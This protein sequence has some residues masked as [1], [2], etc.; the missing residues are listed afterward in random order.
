MIA[1]VV[2]RLDLALAVNGA[3]ELT[4]PDD[5]G[6]F[7]Q[8]PRLEILN[9]RRARLVGILALFAKALGQIAVLIPAAM[10]KLDETRPALGHAAR[11]QTVVGEA[12]GL[13]HVRPVEVERRLGF[14]RD[15]HQLRHRGL[16]PKR[17]LI[18]LDPRRGLRI[19]IRF[20]LLRVQLC[21]AIEHS[22]AFRGIDAGWVRQE[23]HR[24]AAAAK[25][26]A[27]IFAGQEA[28]TPKPGVERLI[29]FLAVGNHDDERG[30]I[31]VLRAE[32]VAQPR[33]HARTARL[34]ESCL[35]EGDRRVMIDRL[36]VDRLDD[37][38][39]VR[40]AR[41]VRQQFTDPRA[42][43]AVLRELE[44]RLH[45]RERALPRGHARDALAVSHGCGQLRLV[46]LLQRRLVVEQV[47]LRRSARHEEVDDALG[48]WREMRITKDGLPRVRLRSERGKQVRIQQRTQR[49][50][51]D[52]SGAAPK[53]V[54]AVD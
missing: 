16:H 26:H 36:G 1:A 40:D 34:L 3:P 10:V 17:H 32:T 49:G 48:F 22:A 8:S 52:A 46:Q 6:V 2:L 4:A 5:Q 14:I 30:K 29:A 18:L 37:G 54:A 25:L 44:H 42:G 39:V 15:I 9:Q 24:V 45:D 50:G 7:Q 13:L 21:H 11:E 47:H 19:L 38:N 12:A 27:L 41:D 20:A 35:D 28:R 51:S 23:Q 43:L 33:P 31:L 53:E